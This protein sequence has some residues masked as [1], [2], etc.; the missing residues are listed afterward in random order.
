[1]NDLSKKILLSFQVRKNKKQKKQFQDLILSSFKDSYSV[2]VEP[3][4]F[5]RSQNIIVGDIEKAKIICTAHYDTCA[6][7]PL[8]N[9]IYPL[10]KVK[11]FLYQLSLYFMLFLP[12]YFILIVLIALLQLPEMTLGFVL[13]IS[14]LLVL[15]IMMWGIANPN[16]A[17]DN[18][19]GVITLIELASKI[20]HE[21][22]AFVF[23]DHEEFGLLGSSAFRKKYKEKMKET[24]L[25]NFDC[26]GDGEHILFMPNK[27][28][29]Q[30][31][32]LMEALQHT[33]QNNH[34]RHGEIQLQEN[35]FYPSDQKGF[36]KSIAIASFLQNKIGQYYM[37]KIHTKKDIIC[38]EKNIDYITERMSELIGTY[39]S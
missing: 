11:T 7:L 16:T 32:K 6:Q 31:V 1:M 8:P 20:D 26:V 30:D 17:N 22:V 34:E 24:L 36:S 9:L 39:F 19:S 37:N 29:N 18:T 12:I 27:K 14:S 23:F 13:L 5:F 10:N 15:W 28:A 35:V 4:G 33:I 2:R 38:D 25:I 3:C 21:E